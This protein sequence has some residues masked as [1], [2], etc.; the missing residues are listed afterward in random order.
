MKFIQPRFSRFSYFGVSLSLTI[1]VLCAQ[2]ERA[3]GVQTYWTAGTGDWTSSGNWSAGVPAF[4]TRAF[5]NN[6]GTARVFVPGTTSEVV[7]LGTNAGDQGTLELSGGALD[8]PQPRGGTMR[9]GNYGSGT[10][11]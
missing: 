4:D 2:T 3:R 10:L 5:I 9:V 6:N 7:E 8:L 11:A 1:M